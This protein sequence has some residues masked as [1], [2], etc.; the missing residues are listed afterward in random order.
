V[1]GDHVLA[2]APADL[3]VA[4]DDPA[5]RRAVALVR[6]NARW[7]ATD[8]LFFEGETEPCINGMAL[9]IGAYFGQ[10][11]D[12]VVGRLMADELDDGGWNCWAAF[13]ATV[14]SFNSTICVLEGLL[15]WERAG[16]FSEA[17]AAARRRGEEYLLGRGLLRRRTNGQVIDPRF[18]MFSFPTR[19]YYDALRALDYFRAAGAEPDERCAEAIA[20]VTDKRDGR[21]GRSRT[22]TWGRPTSR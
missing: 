16:G 20:L 2:A 17:V 3:G 12:G 15:E 14:S 21:A 1:D 11:G 18:T 4:P 7:E 13:G 19:W 8:T 9:A 22:P 5:V 6:D 10:D